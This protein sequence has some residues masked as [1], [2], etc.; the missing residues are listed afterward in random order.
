M[1]WKPR[2]EYDINLL[3]YTSVFEESQ[4]S[5]FIAFFFF[6]ITLPFF[7]RHPLPWRPVCKPSIL[8]FS[9]ALDLAVPD[10]ALCA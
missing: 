3:C 10:A 6:S 4:A 7:T 2:V 1:R 8:L 9:S 5:S